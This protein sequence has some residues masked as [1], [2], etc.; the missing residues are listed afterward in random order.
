MNKPRPVDRVL[1]DRLLKIRKRLSVPVPVVTQDAILEY[2]IVSPEEFICSKQYYNA[3]QHGGEYPEIWP[4][5]IEDMT[6]IFSGPDFEPK[7]HTFVDIEGTGS[8]KS[9]KVALM[10]VYNIYRLHC[11]KDPAVALGLKSRTSIVFMNLAPTANQA[12]EIV[13]DDIVE[14]VNRTRCFKERGWLPNPNI[15]RHLRFERKRIR[16][17]PGNSS[18]NV[19]LGYCVYGA[20]IDEAQHFIQATNFD[21]VKDLYELVCD[22]RESR[23]GNRGLVSLI[24]DARTTNAYMEALYRRAG[25]VFPD[26]DPF[27]YGIRRP[28]WEAN[29][30]LNAMERF[31]VKVTIPGD[32]EPETIELHPPVCYKH[33]FETN[34]AASVRT[35]A[36]IPMITVS[37]FMNWHTILNTINHNRVDPCPDLGVGVEEHPV[38]RLNPDRTIKCIGVIDRLA[39]DFVGDTGTRYFIHVD[40]ARAK[41][42]GKARDCAGFAMVHSGPLVERGGQQWP[43]VVLDLAVRFKGSND[44]PV[45]FSHVRELINNLSTVRKFNIGGITY[46]GWQ[47]Y[48]SIDALVDAG[49]NVDIRHVGASEFG[50]LKELIDGRRFDYYP[51]KRL[52]YEL[53]RLEDHNGK[54]EAV[55]GEHDDEAYAVAGAVANALSMPE[56]ESQKKRARLGASANKL[57]GSMKQ[58]LPTNEDTVAPWRKQQRVA[59]R[60]K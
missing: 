49:L 12:K 31:T 48:D 14:A 38:T 21:P 28:R 43:T 40:L 42:A 23:F 11:Y 9:T 2:P 54:V 5:L 41:D 32:E 15:R 57:F 53:Q 3:N 46:D 51:D 1:I 20:V 13:F 8:G 25:N 7:Y 56:E 18:E 27:I 26:G 50:T 29:P 55:F 24:S 6:N 4:S 58:R 17:A 36:A 52:V 59:G 35:I 19:A 22:R 33:N 47:S 45:N 30:K 10:N 60:D 16:V 39:A 37:P 44:T 34:L